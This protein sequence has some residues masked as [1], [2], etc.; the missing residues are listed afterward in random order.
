MGTGTG[1]VVPGTGVSLQNR[2]AGF[3]LDPDHGNFL[4]PGK[5]PFHTIIPAMTELDGELHACFGVMGG[6]MQPQGHLQVLSHLID[7]GLSPQEALDAPRWRI[8]AEDAA[9]TAPDPGGPLLVEED[10]GHEVLEALVMR[11]HRLRKVSGFDRIG[12]G[13]GQVI[14]RDPESG[15]LT[16]GSDPRKDGCALGY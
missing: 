9:S 4:A 14:L 12:M 5:R 1:L 16:G 2:G 7:R 10:L 3:S 6:P 8:G 13:G 15:V 11:G